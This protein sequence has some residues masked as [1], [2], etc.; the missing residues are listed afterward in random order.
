MDD[1]HLEQLR[2]IRAEIHDAV[3][4]FSVMGGICV[5]LLGVIAFKG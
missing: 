5:V 2:I 4:T 1:L 3:V